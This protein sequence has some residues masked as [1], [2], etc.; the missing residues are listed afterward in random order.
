MAIYNYRAFVTKNRS[1]RNQK[2]KLFTERMFI[3]IIS[4]EMTIACTIFQNIRSF[5]DILPNLRFNVYNGV[6]IFDRRSVN[7][8]RIRLYY[9]CFYLQSHRF[10]TKHVLIYLCIGEKKGKDNKIGTKCD[11]MYKVRTQI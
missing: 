9:I 4:C 2:S 10:H 1:Y 11:M 7:P 3:S 6:T 5:S 8:D